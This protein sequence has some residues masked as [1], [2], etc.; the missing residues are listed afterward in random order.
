LNASR[1]YRESLCLIRSK[2]SFILM[3]IPDDKDLKKFYENSG[4]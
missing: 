3:S 4:S 2:K 1:R